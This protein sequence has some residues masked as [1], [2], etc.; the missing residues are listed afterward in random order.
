MNSMHTCFPFPLSVLCFG[1]C[2]ISLSLVMASELFPLLSVLVSFL[3]PLSSVLMFPLCLCHILWSHLHAS[4]CVCVCVCVMQWADTSY[5]KK[6]DI[7]P[8]SLVT[9][10]RQ[11]VLPSIVPM[12]QHHV[13]PDVR[14]NQHV[15]HVYA[16]KCPDSHFQCL[17]NG[18]CLPVFVRCNGFY[19]CPSREDESECDQYTCPGFYRC[20]GVKTCLHPDHVCD[21]LPH[22]PQQDDERYCDVDCPSQCSCRGLAF[23]CHHPINKWKYQLPRY[24]DVSKTNV[25][26]THPVLFQVL[27]RQ[28]MLVYLNLQLCHLTS[29]TFPKMRNLKILDARYRTAKLVFFLNVCLFVFFL[30]IPSNLVLLNMVAI[31]LFLD[32]NLTGVIFL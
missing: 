11:A 29:L 30:E 26:T 15:Q 5:P 13:I 4:S 28:K 8:P 9:F 22:C 23:T 24:L 10:S 12:L 16:S 20:R 7:K 18:H 3:F 27:H 17:N 31:L 14:N 2:T 19:D 32:N 25:D 6:F 1:V 21:G